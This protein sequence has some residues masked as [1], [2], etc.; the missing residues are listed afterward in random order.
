LNDCWRVRVT[1]NAYDLDYDYGP[2]L[3][4]RRHIVNGY[5]NYEL[6]FGKGQPFSTAS[7]ADKIIGG[8]R[9]TSQ[10]PAACRSNS[11]KAPGR[12]SAKRRCSATPSV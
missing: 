7:L 1:A 10:R 9:V 2:S 4:D 6:P 5:F 11:C 3:F 12:N 8:W